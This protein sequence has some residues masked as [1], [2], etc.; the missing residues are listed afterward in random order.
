MALFI[1]GKTRCPIC[2]LPIKEEDDLIAFPPFIGDASD[3]LWMFSDGTFHYQCLARHPLAAE[4]ERRS[5]EWRTRSR[6]GQRLCIVCSEEIVQPN[7]YGT[8]GHLTSDQEDPLFPFN[9]VQFHKSHLGLWPAWP[10]VRELLQSRIS[11][12]HS[13]SGLEMLLAELANTH[14]ES[15][16]PPPSEPSRRVD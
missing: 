15:E 16:S 9:Y 7:D 3:P 10:Q 13:G 6:P 8:L 11:T 12:E 1:P 4:A 2:E 14:A 5:L